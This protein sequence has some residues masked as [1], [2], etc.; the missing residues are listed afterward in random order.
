MPILV[1]KNTKV[2]CQAFT[3]Q[4]GTSHCEQVIACH[5]RIVQAVNGGGR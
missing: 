4:N 5:A 3:G 1:D 2:I